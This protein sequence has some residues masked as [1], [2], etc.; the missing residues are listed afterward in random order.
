M[1]TEQELADAREA[2][3]EHFRSGST[4]EV[5]A[6]ARNDA[7]GIALIE[8]PRGEGASLIVADL[9]DSD[10]P[11]FVAHAQVLQHEPTVQTFG[12][13]A[14]EYGTPPRFNYLALRLDKWP[15]RLGVRSGAKRTELDVPAP[16]EWLLYVEAVDDFSSELSVEIFAQGEW[17]TY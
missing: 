10:A 7:A 6:A 1:W 12:A 4:G 11:A 2:A 16:G 3:L 8:L 14:T 13:V 9:R 17:V 15:A 5:L